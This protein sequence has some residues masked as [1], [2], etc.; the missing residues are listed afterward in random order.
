MIHPMYYMSANPPNVFNIVVPGL[1][2]GREPAKNQSRRHQKIL[3]RGKCDRCQCDWSKQLTM[4]TLKN[5]E[6][7]IRDTRNVCDVRDCRMLAILSAALRIQSNHY[8]HHQPK[9]A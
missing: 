4:H 8:A 5:L 3:V 7:S 1:R 9:L 2:N 6:A